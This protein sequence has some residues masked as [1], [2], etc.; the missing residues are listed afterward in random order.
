MVLPPGHGLAIATPRKLSA[1]EKRL[2]RGVLAVVAVIVAALIVS[3]ATTG[4]SSAHGCIRTTIPGDVGA[5]QINECGA[6]ARETCQTVHQPGAFA[7]A[8]ARVVAAACRKAGLPV[9]G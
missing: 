8:S 7:A 1:R 3:I 9:G 6:Q 4:Q 5:Q 2:I